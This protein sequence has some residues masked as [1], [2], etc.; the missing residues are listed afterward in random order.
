MWL[1]DI[2]QNIIKWMVSIPLICT[3]LLVTTSCIAFRSNFFGPSS[4]FEVFCTLFW[5]K[6]LRTF[7]SFI[8]HSSLLFRFIYKK[9]K[10]WIWWILLF[11]LG[12]VGILAFWTVYI[13]NYINVIIC[14]LNLF[15][16]CYRVIVSVWLFQWWFIGNFMLKWFIVTK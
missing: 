11:C 4:K 13:G 3:R 15:V 6:I 1:K 14:L 2:N 7:W 16:N 12:K 8:S 9:K 10:M 5:K